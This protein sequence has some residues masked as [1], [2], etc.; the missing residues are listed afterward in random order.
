MSY[1]D[2]LHKSI[3]QSPFRT[4]YCF[5]PNCIVDSPPVLLSD[6]ASALTRDWS[7]HFNALRKHLLKAK[8]DFK[9]Y[10]D[11]KKV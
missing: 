7:S 2:S 11:P 8:E 10:A 4:S 3:G 6:P 5:N 1:N 9:K